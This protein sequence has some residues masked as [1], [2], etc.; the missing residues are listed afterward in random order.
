MK[1]ELVIAKEKIDIDVLKALIY[2]WE[3]KTNRCKGDYSP[4]GNPDYDQGICDC[5]D[6]LEEALIH[7]I[8]AGK[9]KL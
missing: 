9:I 2:D 5:I 6:D 4:S 3:E 8:F 1:T 7:Y